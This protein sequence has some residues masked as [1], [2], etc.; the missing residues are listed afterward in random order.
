MIKKKMLICGLAEIHLSETILKMS[1]SGNINKYTDRIKE[2]EKKV[3]ELENEKKFVEGLFEK[4]ADAIFIA[5]ID[6]GIIVNANKQAEKLLGKSKNEIIGTHQQALHPPEMEQL[7]T[8]TFNRAQTPEFGEGSFD[9]L[10]SFIINSSGKKIPVEIHAGIIQYKWK[11]ALE[12]IFRDISKRKESETRLFATERKYKLIA[13]SINDIVSMHKLTGEIIYVSP[14]LFNVMAW[15]PN[16]W[17]GRR[18][19]EMSHTEDVE[20]V[21]QA[22]SD[23]NVEP[24]KMIQWRALTSDG[25]YIWM[26][27]LIR[28][29]FDDLRN[30]EVLIASSRNITK[31]KTDDFKILESELKYRTLFET[32]GDAIFLMDKEIFIDCNDKTL[33]M[34]RCKRQDVINKPPY[35]FSPSTQP[36]GRDSQ[37]KAL[38]KINNA[39][40]DKPQFFEWVHKRLDGELFDAEVSLNQ[41]ELYGKTYLQAIVRDISKRKNAERALRSSEENY[42][43]LVEKSPVPMFIHS[44]NLILFA[45][46]AGLDLIEAEDISQVINKQIYEFAHPESRG[47]VHHKFDDLNERK[48]EQGSKIEKFITFKGN[49]IVC[50]VSSIAFTFESQASS[51][52]VMRDI[53]KE[54]EANEALRESESL[55]RNALDG[56][57]DGVWEFDLDS[58]QL[59]LSDN[60]YDVLGYKNDGSFDIS[61]NWFKLLKP[62][63]VE[64]ITKM[65]FRHIGNTKDS[66]DFEVSI[67]TPSGENRWILQRGR[68]FEFKRTNTKRKFIGILTDITRPKEQEQNLEI[69]KIELEKALQVKDNFLS[70]IAH[71]LKSP[72]SG[73]QALSKNLYESLDVTNPEDFREIMQEFYKSSDNILNLIENLLK[74]A[75]INRGNL[76]PDPKILKVKELLSENLKL[77]R[78]LI[79]TKE[80]GVSVNIPNELTVFADQ[81]M[82]DTVV[83]NILTN[84]VKFCRRY[85]SITIDA[86]RSENVFVLIFSD[87]GIGMDSVKL[88]NLFKVDKYQS[89]VGTGG[90]QG[91]G[92]G[93]IICKELIEKMNGAINIESTPGKGTKVIITFKN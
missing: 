35:L 50:E 36:D 10:D 53:T 57:N 2:L 14:S 92:L 76:Q 84:A 7:V 11:K 78:Q 12:G 66:F 16:N 55:L 67:K 30:D 41:I 49:E 27:T 20:I 52:V 15:S 6:T 22:F 43:N 56:V 64:A 68:Y 80:I 82:L 47:S 85:D 86:F 65:V 37:S 79:T 17:T 48:I 25:N 69:S 90:E 93:L 1:K 60:C 89:S 58:R 9:T 45:N 75:R 71:D 91:S 31:Q 63:D 23:T 42:K 8:E 4:A 29:V 40:N 88:N 59:F 51:L 38:E 62:K 18:I 70:L 33:T 28:R 73:L 87:T 74:W 81:E 5:D 19:E 44:N 39:I 72:L 21:K 26:E 77:L 13:E 54:I 46:K 3:Q 34:F 61:K 32:A 24:Q 83:R